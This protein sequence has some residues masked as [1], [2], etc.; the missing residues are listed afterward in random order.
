MSSS[1]V[2]RV[3]IQTFWEFVEVGIEVDVRSAGL[4]N[5]SRYGEGLKLKRY[6]V[7]S[8]M[9]TLEEVPYFLRGF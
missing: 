2:K 4:V 7:I 9:G 1:N 8:T 3:Y 6:F 5:F